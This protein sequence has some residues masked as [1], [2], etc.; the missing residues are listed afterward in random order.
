MAMKGH[1]SSFTPTYLLPPAPARPRGTYSSTMSTAQRVTCSWVEGR[2]T[3]YGV[4][5]TVANMGR[6]C[7]LTVSSLVMPLTL[8]LRRCSLI[9]LMST[10]CAESGPTPHVHSSRTV[11][12]TIIIRPAIMA[13]WPSRTVTLVVALKTVVLF[14]TACSI[15]AL[16]NDGVAVPSP[17]DVDTV[18]H[19]VPIHTTSINSTTE[20]AAF[21]DAVSRALSDNTVTAIANVSLPTQDITDGFRQYATLCG[22]LHPDGAPMLGTM[23]LPTSNRTNNVSCHAVWSE[24]NHRGS[25]KVA[26][27]HR[28]PNVFGK[29]VGAL[30]DAVEN[31]TGSDCSLN[32]YLKE[33]GETLLDL[34]RDPYAV[35]AVQVAGVNNW[36]V[37]TDDAYEKVRGGPATDVDLGASCRHIVTRA[38]DALFLPK[39]TA[40]SAVSV[41]IQTSVHLTLGML[42]TQNTWRGVLEGIVQRHPD[43]AAVKKLHRRL[44]RIDANHE[45]YD[46]YVPLRIQKSQLLSEM[47]LRLHDICTG[48]EATCG[49]FTESQVR[50]GIL[51]SLGHHRHIRQ[52]TPGG[53]T[54]GTQ[55]ATFICPDNTIHSKNLS[56]GGG[57][58]CCGCDGW[59]SGSCDCDCT[60]PNYARCETDCSRCTCPRGQRLEGC[61]AASVYEAGRCVVN[62]PGDYCNEGSAQ[63]FCAVGL[64]CLT[65]R[66]CHSNV[67]VGNCLACEANTGN[68]IQHATGWTGPWADRCN[69]SHFLDSVTGRCLPLGSYGDSCASDGQCHS[70]SCKGGRC[71]ADEVAD[72]VRCNRCG[73]HGECTACDANGLDA[74]T[75]CSSCLPG[76]YSLGHRLNLNYTQCAPVQL[77]TTHVSSTQSGEAVRSWVSIGLVCLVLF[78]IFGI[79]ILV[80]R[81]RFNCKNDGAA[82]HPAAVG[83]ARQHPE[84]LLSPL[85]RVT[86]FYN[87]AF[88]QNPDCASKQGIVSTEGALTLDTTMV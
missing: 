62:G 55:D 85:R 32:A 65:S 84:Q 27:P 46:L 66:C 72:S 19:G 68:C 28:Y 24:R 12:P 45:D 60:N 86:S 5:G 37:C 11:Y 81:N 13:P 15:K 51:D 73:Q 2:R 18:T 79:G 67:R 17:P 77:N 26:A 87:P 10:T 25:T 41:G 33:Y 82:P 1:S 74:V 31:M 47:T 52:V 50:D 4:L 9:K 69:A 64:S 8:C 14:T 22:G 43:K 80:F 30:V 21:R 56:G 63:V 83:G 61:S 16:S 54:A 29:G 88:D 75:T 23:N 71:C 35:L 36:T 57:P 38:G 58:A 78:I 34:H 7:C 70:G 40:H 53:C 44:R 20:S 42:A 76:F 59:F 6:T 3:G 39:H 48:T 49:F